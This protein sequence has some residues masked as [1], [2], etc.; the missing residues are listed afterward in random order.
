MEKIGI[1]QNVQENIH[2]K[3]DIWKTKAREDNMA[4]RVIGIG[5][6]GPSTDHRVYNI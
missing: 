2:G 5:L 4:P 3:K 1:T 6:S